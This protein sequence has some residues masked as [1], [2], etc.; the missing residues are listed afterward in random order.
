MV[1]IRLAETEGLSGR[2]RAG[3]RSGSFGRLLLGRRAGTFLPL[4]RGAP[5][6]SH[7]A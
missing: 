3:S 1:F 2:R 4:L 7:K 5:S 6:C